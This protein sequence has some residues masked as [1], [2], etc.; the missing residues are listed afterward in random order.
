MQADLLPTAEVAR[1]AGVNVK[2][3]HRW[4][5]AGRL[6]PAVVAPGPRGAR[7]FDRRDVA[8]LLTE[9]ERSA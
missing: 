9:L 1:L 8:L 2:T 5:E 7:L 6:T 3:I 4:V